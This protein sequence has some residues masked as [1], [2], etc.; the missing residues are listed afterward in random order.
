MLLNQAPS[1]FNRRGVTKTRFSERRIKVEV[2][3][4]MVS[5]TFL[6][7]ETKFR[8]IHGRKKRAVKVEGKVR[9]LNEVKEALKHCR[10]STLMGLKTQKCSSV[11]S[12]AVVHLQSSRSQAQKIAVSSGSEGG[13]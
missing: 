11:V 8:A 6:V 13:I 7:L 3:D 9:W 2:R 10:D 1:S 12:M 5:L 4:R